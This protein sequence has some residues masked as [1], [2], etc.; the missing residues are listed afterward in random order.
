[1][2]RL[3]TIPQVDEYARLTECRIM[4]QLHFPLSFVGE[5]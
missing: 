1:M 4:V 5:W 2:C 3:A